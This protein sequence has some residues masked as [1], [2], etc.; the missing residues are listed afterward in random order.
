VKLSG[1]QL[2]PHWFA[3][4]AREFELAADVKRAT[5]LSIVGIVAGELV[6]THEVL[7]VSY[8][9]DLDLSLFTYEPGP[10]ESVQAAIPVAEHVTWE[11]AA[12]RAPFTLLRPTF[13][14]EGHR[15]LDEVTYHPARPS[16][17]DEHVTIFYRGD[18]S[19]CSLWITQRKERDVRSHE[20]FA[21]DELNID[22]RVF[23]L[24]D[25]GTDD[26]LRLLTFEQEG[27][28]VNIT[29][30]LPTEELVKIARSMQAV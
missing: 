7:E 29:S 18:R 13:I 1:A 6:E 25:P 12:E 28:D 23:E 24:S 16:S 19:A 20:K 10:R 11:I 22:G 3:W 8:D 14:P 9:E 30:D 21:W 4:E 15:G 17:L 5:L 26:G 2:W 27:T